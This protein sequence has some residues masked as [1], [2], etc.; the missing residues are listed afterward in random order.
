MTLNYNTINRAPS[1]HGLFIKNFDAV[2]RMI[3]FVD[4]R[5]K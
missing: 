3:Q 4:N 2:N 1:P 5:I